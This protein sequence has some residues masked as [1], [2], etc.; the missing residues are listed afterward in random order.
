MVGAGDVNEQPAAR[1]NDNPHIHDLVVYDVG[2]RK[3]LGV[4]TY[5]AP[6]QPDNGRDALQDAY[7]EVL[8]LA[9]YLRQLIFERDAEEVV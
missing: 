6:L 5:G 3:K 1:L 2:Q 9:C 7:E 8:D 4:R